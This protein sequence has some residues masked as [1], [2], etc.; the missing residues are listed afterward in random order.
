M[1]NHRLK[2]IIK[3]NIPLLIFILF[4][5]P[6]YIAVLLPIWIRNEAT[7]VLQ[8]LGGLGIYFLIFTLLPLQVI[9]W[10]YYTWKKTKKK[11]HKLSLLLLTLIL[12]IWYFFYLDLEYIKLLQN[13]ICIWF[14]TP[15]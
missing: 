11:F 7:W 12:V 2:K 15:Q 14:S 5:I 1:L 6:F 8:T 4:L 13:I 9:I 3:I 10:I